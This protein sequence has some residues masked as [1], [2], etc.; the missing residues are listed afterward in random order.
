MKIKTTKTIILRTTTAVKA[1]KKTALYYHVGSVVH[2]F[3]LHY[4]RQLFIFPQPLNIPQIYNVS[5]FFFP[6]GK[7]KSLNVLSG[8]RKKLQLFSCFR[9][10]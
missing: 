8:E 10:L 1:K 2:R 6:F 3:T 5:F 9:Q 4:L 7:K